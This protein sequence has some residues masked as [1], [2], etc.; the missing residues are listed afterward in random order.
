MLLSRK[1][2]LPF[3]GGSSNHHEEGILCQHFTRPAAG[4]MGRCVYSGRNWEGFSP[5]PY[6]SGVAMELGI[7]GLQNA[8]VQAVAKHLIAN[9]QE[10]QRNPVYYPNGTVRFEAISSNVDDRTL[11][12]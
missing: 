1:L 4:P 3:H 2:L 12:K 11:R 9:E 5:D 6:L 7:K 10:I 8:G